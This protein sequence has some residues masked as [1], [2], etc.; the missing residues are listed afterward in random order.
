MSQKRKV[1]RVASAGKQGAINTYST[2]RSYLLPIWARQ[3]FVQNMGYIAIGLAIILGFLSMFA[4]VLVFNAL[5][6][7]II[8]R[9]AIENGAGISAVLILI[10]FLLVALSIKPLFS[11]LLIGWNYILGAVVVRS[12]YHVVQGEYV[13]AAVLP[14]VSLYVLFQIRHYYST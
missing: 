3:F 10:Q 6:L 12:V 5:P 13:A 7:G 14:M 1:K 8:G 4:A 2:E 9:P 11:K